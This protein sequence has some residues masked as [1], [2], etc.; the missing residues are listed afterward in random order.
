MPLSLGIDGDHV[1]DTVLPSQVENSQSLPN[2]QSSKQQPVVQTA[3]QYAG[4]ETRGANYL[5]AS[6]GSSSCKLVL[7]STTVVQLV[8]V[9]APA[10]AHER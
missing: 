1:H 6:I 8:V 5:R 7:A 4:S 3:L 10:P 2:R 9:A